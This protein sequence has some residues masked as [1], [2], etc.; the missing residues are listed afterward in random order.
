MS[1]IGT[2]AYLDIETT[3]LDPGNCEIT[4]VGIYLTG[5]REEVVQL[6]GSQIKGEVILDS[7]QG[8]KSLY[9]YNG[10][11]FDLPFINSRH[12]VNLE[13]C[14]PHYD[15]MYHCWRKNLY[16]G[17]KAVEQCLGIPRQLKEVNG[18]VAIRLWW[19]YVNDYD[20]QAL[21]IL[22]DYNRED[23]INLKALK[24]KLQINVC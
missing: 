13:R 8:V 3:G 5:E 17:L 12:G 7:L 6:V 19:R 18:L 10:G 21:K 24:E 14:F 20:Q 22:L 16:G 1:E 4:V 15:L 11:R 23:I 2:E 9:T